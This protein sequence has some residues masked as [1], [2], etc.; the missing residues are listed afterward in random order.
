M[1]SDEDNMMMKRIKAQKPIQKVKQKKPNQNR[2]NLMFCNPLRRQMLKL[3]HKYD[4][5]VLSVKSLTFTESINI[6]SKLNSVIAR[7]VI[8]NQQVH[9][10]LYAVRQI[11]IFSLM[12]VLTGKD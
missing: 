12:N 9:L 3:R 10:L 8:V 11:R 5:K 4:P 2:S 7:L 1:E 6:F